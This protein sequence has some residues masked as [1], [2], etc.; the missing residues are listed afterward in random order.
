M[1]VFGCL[2]FILLSNIL[3]KLEPFAVTDLCEI[4]ASEDISSFRDKG[5]ISKLTVLRITC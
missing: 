4:Q 5:A 3:E 1:R 2:Y